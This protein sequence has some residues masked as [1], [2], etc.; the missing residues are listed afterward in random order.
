M[1]SLTLLVLLI[2]IILNA[3]A[4]ILVKASTTNTNKENLI[5]IITNFYLI[6][7]L[8]SFCLAFLAYR[9]VLSRGFA[10]SITYPIMTSA[11]FAIVIIASK[12]LFNENMTFIQWIGIIFLVIGIWLITFKT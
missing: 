2:A 7:G 6:S 11:G 1:N 4:N 3:I 5:D 12:Y 9:Y 8:I 10:L